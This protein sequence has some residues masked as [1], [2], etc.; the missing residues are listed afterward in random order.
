MTKYEKM[1]LITEQNDGYLMISV[2]QGAGI[3]RTYLSKYV[4]DREMEQVEP[5]IYIHPEI[6]PDQFY[7][8]QLKNKGVFFL[9][10]LHCIFMGLWNVSQQEL[11][12]L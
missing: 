11:L 5:G 4:K 9:M 1:D 10:K 12:F 3:S 6:W 2:V 7:I 8:L